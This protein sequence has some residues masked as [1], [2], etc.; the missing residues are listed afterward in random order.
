MCVLL[1]PAPRCLCQPECVEKREKGEKKGLVLFA[2]VENGAVT[3]GEGG[4][5]VAPRLKL[6]G[7]A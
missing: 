2:T 5:R 7:V 4:S 1:I 3:L 6:E